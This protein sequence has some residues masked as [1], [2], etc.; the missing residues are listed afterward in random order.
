MIETKPTTGPAAGPATGPATGPGTDTQSLDDRHKRYTGPRVFEPDHRPIC[1]INPF[2]G[3]RWRDDDSPLG[4][5]R[6]YRGEAGLAL[7]ARQIREAYGLGVRRFE[8]NR[9]AGGELTPLVTAAQYLTMDAAWRADLALVLYRLRQDLDERIE[10]RAYAG[11]WFDRREDQAGFPTKTD[12]LLE[13]WHDTFLGYATW[14]DTVVLD[15]TTN[16]PEYLDRVQA[17]AA[18]IGVMVAGEAVPFDAKLDGYWRADLLQR[19]PY[20]AQMRP[21]MTKLIGSPPRPRSAF[22]PPFPPGS[23]V[24]LLIRSPELPKPGSVMR[25]DTMLAMARAMRTRLNAVTL[26]DDLDL[27]KAAVAADEGGA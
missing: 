9:P 27:L 26:T 10:I 3:E 20:W 17:A 7:L 21:F 5:Q 22:A 2:G 14:A 25:E 1:W 11:A 8:I 15:A 6:R 19:R 12:P 13:A 23:E 18:P 16:L 24:S 4:I